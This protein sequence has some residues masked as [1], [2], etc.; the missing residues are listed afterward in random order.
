[1][2]TRKQPAATPAR[3][4]GTVTS[5]KAEVREQPRSCAASISES[6]IFSSVA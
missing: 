1:M 4:S 5:Q 3:D 2:N 6:S